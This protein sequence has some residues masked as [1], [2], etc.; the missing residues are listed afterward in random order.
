MD[1]ELSRRLKSLLC[2]PDVENVI[3]WHHRIL[4]AYHSTEFDDERSVG[5]TVSLL[6]HGSYELRL[7]ELPRRLQAGTD[8]LWL[9]LF[10]HDHE[11]TIDS[12]SGRTLVDI[13]AAAESLCSNAKYLSH[14]D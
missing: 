4:E 10:D 13:T 1:Y 12:Y 14:T 8:Q 5:R 9:E 7:V 2:K 3:V 11:R 6:R